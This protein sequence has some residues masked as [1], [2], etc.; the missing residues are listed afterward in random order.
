VEV[1]WDGFAKRTFIEVVGVDVGV[2]GR[3]DTV[4]EVFIFRID[5]VAVAVAFWTSGTV[6]VV[7][8]EEA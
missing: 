7:L 2:D 6:I 1:E 4:E 3:M 5:A 8:G